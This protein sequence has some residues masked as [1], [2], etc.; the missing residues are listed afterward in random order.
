M[1]GVIVRIFATRAL[2]N[3]GYGWLTVALALL[4]E[5]R[6]YTSQLVGALFTIGLIA[7]AAY[8]ASTSRWVR[9]FDR[10]TTLVIASLLMALSGVCLWFPH[11]YVPTLVAMLLGTVGLGTQEVGP[12]TSLEQTLIADA[13][14]SKAGSVF[15]YYNVIGLFAVAGGAAIPIVAP[16]ETAPLG[17][18]AIALL[19]A[20]LYMTMPHVPT[21]APRAE[22]P[23][24][25][26]VPRAVERLTA[27]F[28]VDAF[29][30]GII[31]QTFLAYWFTVRFHP[32]AEVLGALFF[33]ANTV[34]AASLLFAAPLARRVGPVHAMV[35][36]HL[37]SNII[38]GFIPLIPSFEW[39]AALLI[40]RFTFSQMDTPV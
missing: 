37:P 17:Y 20:A 1:N 19:Q 39:A 30:G 22:A 25:A 36:T 14:G 28:A 35:Y 6:G 7:G 12:F 24:A 11:G 16:A 4:L 5:R 31:V 32:S 33:V 21:P 15:G 10:R 2:R 27:F 29:G 9:R 34:A 8:A 3:V 13:S 23:I 40:F 38:L 18:A 26:H